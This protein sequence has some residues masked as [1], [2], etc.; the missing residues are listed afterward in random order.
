MCLLNCLKR[1][2]FMVSANNSVY[3][4]KDRAKVGFTN[5]TALRQSEDGQSAKQTVFRRDSERRAYMDV[6]TACLRGLCP[7][8]SC[9]TRYTKALSLDLCCFFNSH[10]HLV[11]S[12]N[13]PHLPNFDITIIIVWRKLLQF[14]FK[15]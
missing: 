6:F 11:P 9:L 2:C 15:G 3:E 1:A 5:K 10:F 7:F 12:D 4:S 8:R 13:Q 14:G